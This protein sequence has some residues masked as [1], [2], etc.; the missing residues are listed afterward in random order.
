MMMMNL[1]PRHRDIA[2]AASL[3]KLQ[4]L[5]SLS[6]ARTGAFRPAVSPQQPVAATTGR[7]VAA[8][9]KAGLF[10]KGRKDAVSRL[11]L[12]CLCPG[13]K[14]LFGKP[15]APA[16]ASRL[17]LEMASRPRYGSHESDTAVPIRAS[18]VIRYPGLGVHGIFS[19]S[20][21]LL[22]WYLTGR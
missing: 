10:V 6:L 9:R 8:P 2:P 22:N 16:P 5:F 21:D 12:L 15:G 19:E 4:R 17:S 1:E 18:S 20:S 3:R 7:M 13:P 14:D 11:K